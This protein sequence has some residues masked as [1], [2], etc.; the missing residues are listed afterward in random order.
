MTLDVPECVAIVV[1]VLIGISGGFLCF[2]LIVD[3]EAETGV[4]RT[5]W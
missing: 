5:L 1:C 3:E 2:D 4:R